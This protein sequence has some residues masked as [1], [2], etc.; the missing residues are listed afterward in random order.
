[1]RYSLVER[2]SSVDDDHFDERNVDDSFRGRKRNR[3]IKM[4][5]RKLKEMENS[6]TWNII[7]AGYKKMR[8]GGG[9]CE[10]RLIDATLS[11]GGGGGGSGQMKSNVESF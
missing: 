3:G 8:G 5:R 11:R 9:A 4:E 2:A 6:L 1:M 7:T 10:A